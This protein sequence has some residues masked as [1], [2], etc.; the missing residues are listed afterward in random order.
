MLTGKQI[1]HQIFSF[2]NINKSLGHPMNLTDLL[3][4]ELHDDNL[5]VFN[6]AWKET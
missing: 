3:N 5:M 6:Q 1:I 4:V 2:F